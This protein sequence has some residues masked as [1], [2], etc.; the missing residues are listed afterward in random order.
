[1]TRA[2]VT[3]RGALAAGGAGALGLLVAGDAARSAGSDGPALAFLL[4]VQ[5]IEAAFYAAAVEAAALTGELRRFA[6]AAAVQ[7]REHVALLAGLTGEAA[8]GELRLR[9]GA[10]VRDARRFARTAAA[11]EDI[12]T[13]A[14]DGQAANLGAAALRDVT[15]IVSVDARHAAWVRDIAG[16]PP[17]GAPLATPLSTDAV[18]TALRREGLIA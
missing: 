16:E 10:A 11:L 13:G 15:R 14:L 9:P 7:E 8:P 4:A 12:A 1:V 17:G 6:A 2:A 18:R 5:R 3:R